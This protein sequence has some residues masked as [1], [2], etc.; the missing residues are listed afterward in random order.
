MLM[1]S[2]KKF[3][4]PPSSY[5]HFGEVPRLPQEKPC[6]HC[7]RSSYTAPNCSFLKATCD[8]NKNKK[9]HFFEIKM[10]NRD[11]VSAKSAE[12]RIL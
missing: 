1:K 8:K 3:K 12:T 11:D 2:W 10:V 4:T 7:G 5:P 6:Y 9:K